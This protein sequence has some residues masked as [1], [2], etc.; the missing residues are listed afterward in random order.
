MHSPRRSLREIVQ[1]QD[2]VRIG[3]RRSRAC[4]AMRIYAVYLDMSNQFNSIL[5]AARAAYGVASVRRNRSEK[6]R[7]QPD[8]HDFRRLYQSRHGLAHF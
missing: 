4:D 5:W 8:E 6:N 7:L 1:G 3:S 2:V